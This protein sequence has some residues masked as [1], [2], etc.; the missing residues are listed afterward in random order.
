MYGNCYCQLSNIN[1]DK[2]FGVFFKNNLT[3]FL[4]GIVGD[5]LTSYQSGQEKG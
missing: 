1:S 3:V 5:S 4:S 2:G